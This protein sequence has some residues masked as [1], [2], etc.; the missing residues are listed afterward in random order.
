MADRP[1]IPRRLEKTL[2]QEANS[3]C[4]ICGEDHV[5]ALEI[6]HIVPFEE[7]HAHNHADMLVLCANCHAKAHGGG[8]SRDQ[9]YKAKRSAKKVIPIRPRP[10]SLGPQTV[11][12]QGL[13]VA[14]GDIIAGGD[15]KVHAPRMVSKP[16]PPIIPN[17]VATNPDKV[18]YLKHL[19]KR[20]IEF[21]EY[22]VGK[23]NMHYPIIY[24]SYEREIGYSINNTPLNRFADACHYLQRRIGNTKLGRMLKSQGRKLYSTFEEFAK[25]DVQ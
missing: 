2:F 3:R 22:E 14:G 1:A 9:L 8:I 16:R 11:T 12:G 25:G 24:K 21:K 19:A 13:I 7:V 20:Y 4:L 15:I 23:G 18:G 10:T 5:A 6:H 17:T